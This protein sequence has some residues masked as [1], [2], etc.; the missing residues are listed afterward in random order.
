MEA[1][2]YVSPLEQWFRGAVMPYCAKCGK[3]L[4]KDATFCPKCGA[5]I[6]GRVTREKKPEWWG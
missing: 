2:I 6:S 5:P 4:D 1:V 3:E